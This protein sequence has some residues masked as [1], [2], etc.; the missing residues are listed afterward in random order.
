MMASMTSEF[1]ATSRK[2]KSKSTLVGLNK[3]VH[4]F[5]DLEAV[6]AK[7]ISLE[8]MILGLTAKTYDFVSLFLCL[9][10]SF[11]LCIFTK[12]IS[13]NKLPSL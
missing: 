8:F 5:I 2:V 7:L 6:V 3:S 12:S 11:F 1:K 9:D 4:C 13:L 10:I